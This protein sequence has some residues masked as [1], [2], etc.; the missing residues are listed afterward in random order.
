M[1]SRVPSGCRVTSHPRPLDG[2]FLIL[3]P[4]LSNPYQHLQQVTR[5]LLGPNNPPKETCWKVLVPIIL[6]Y[7]HT[8]SLN[9]RQSGRH[10]NSC[11]DL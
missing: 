4:P 5:D 7:N 6:L 3:P 1:W 8:T 2:T 9:M 11:F 10:P